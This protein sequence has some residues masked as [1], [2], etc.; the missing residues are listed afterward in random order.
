MHGKMRESFVF[1]RSYYE[2]VS[3]LT[4]Q[5]QTKIFQAICKYALDGEEP[6]LSGALEAVFILIKP[7]IDAN[8]K[9]YENG[10]KEKKTEAS[11]K[12]SKK[13]RKK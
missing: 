3:K 13:K 1:Y 11:G 8:N 10:K 4:L 12:R 5:Q 9:K 7:Q 2:A 6:E